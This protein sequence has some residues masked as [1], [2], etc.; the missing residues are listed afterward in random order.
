MAAIPIINP[1]ANLH[2]P[3]T[4]PVSHTGR[5]IGIGIFVIIALF[6]IIY[7]PIAYSYK[8]WPWAS[9]STC[10]V[11]YAFATDG[12]TCNVCATGYTFASDGKTCNVCA[13]GYSFGSDKVTCSLTGTT[14]PK[15]NTNYE[16]DNTN[17]EDDDT[18]YEDDDTTPMG[19]TP[20]GTTPMGTTPMGTTPIGTTPMGTTP[21]GTTPIGTTP[22]GT[23]PIGTAFTPPTIPGYTTTGV[24]TGVVNTGSTFIGGNKS[25]SECA[26]LCTNDNTC[27]GG[28]LYNYSTKNCYFVLKPATS[29][30]V[31]ST[32][33]QIYY[34]RTTPYSPAT[35]TTPMGTTR[36]GSVQ[37][38]VISNIK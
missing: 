34:A 1:L 21:I 20:M 31:S 30:S 33:S 9:P 8:I 2:V 26:D 29:G 17:Y 27:K 6:C 36:P 4:A 24:H 23:T 37:G 28:I 5:N 3:A 14:A 12:K 38:L 22:I 19:T 7:F 18:N 16:D 32:T 10:N 11:G 35:Q 15:D 13:T 25:V